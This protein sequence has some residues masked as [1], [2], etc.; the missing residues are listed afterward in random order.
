MQALICQPVAAPALLSAEG[1]VGIIFLLTVALVVIGA[2]IAVNA[3]R[4][5][6]AVAGLAVC[7][8]GLAGVYYFLLSPFLAMMQ[9][10]IYVGAVSILIAFGI[11]MAT[12]EEQQTPGMKHRS[13]LAGPLAFSVA[14]LIFAALTLLGLKTQ[15]QVFPRQGSFDI[16]AVGMSLLTTHGMVFELISIV[17]LLAIIGALV[18]AQ[19]GRN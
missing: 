12:P 5:V 18:L 15:W 13:A 6:R 3:R 1:A 2:L 14:A 8:T 9:M 11:M 17:L 16:K 19:R 10:L 7:F 4:L